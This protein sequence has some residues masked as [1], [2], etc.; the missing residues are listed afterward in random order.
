MKKPVPELSTIGV[1]TVPFIHA[2]VTCRVGEDVTRPVN[3]FTSVYCHI[4]L[5]ERRGVI[6]LAQEVRPYFHHDHLSLMRDRVMD[7]CRPVFCIKIHTHLFNGKP[8]ASAVIWEK[9][10]M[11]MNLIY[12]PSIL[13]SLSPP[14]GANTWRKVWKE[15]ILKKTNP[16]SYHAESM[17]F[18]VTIVCCDN[19]TETSKAGIS[20]FVSLL[21]RNVHTFFSIRPSK[22]TDTLAEADNFAS[23][24]ILMN[25]IDTTPTWSICTAILETGMARA[26]WRNWPPST[27]TDPSPVTSVIPLP[28]MDKK[29]VMLE[30][31]GTLGK[32]MGS[33]DENRFL[34]RMVAYCQIAMRDRGAEHVYVHFRNDFRSTTVCYPFPI[35]VSYGASE[36]IHPKIRELPP[37]RMNDLPCHYHDLMR[38][39]ELARMCKSSLDSLGYAKVKMGKG[40]P[41]KTI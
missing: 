23:I 40:L 38:F 19:L 7:G 33:Y 15:L 39:M 6:L 28:S 26:G 30:L 18:H 8:N 32:K 10:L 29:V 11:F 31:W 37:Y 14:P 4:S 9:M 3:G 1:L 17:A 36:I 22:A 34:E 2:G 21:P 41:A 16:I 24:P 13:E 35:K 27:R 20:E 5:K 25:L 12:D